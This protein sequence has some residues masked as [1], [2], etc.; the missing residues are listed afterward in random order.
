VPHYAAFN[1]YGPAILSAADGVWRRHEQPIVEVNGQFAIGLPGLPLF[2]TW[3]M[4]R[5]SSRRY[6]GRSTLTKPANWMQ[7]VGYVTG[8]FTWEADYKS[9]CAGKE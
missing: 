2:P 4:T 9:G 7:E 3:E 1:R 8:G 5:Y 6:S